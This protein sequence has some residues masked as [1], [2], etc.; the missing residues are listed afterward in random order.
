MHLKNGANPN[1]QYNLGGFTPL[2][3]AVDCAVDG[4]IQNNCEKPY[5]E[6][7]E[8]IKILLA[9]GADI[10]MKDFSGETVFDLQMTKEVA[11]LLNAN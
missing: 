1:Q 3:W 5:P 4:M 2:H 10:N 9:Y 8:C 11:D 6:P 7:L